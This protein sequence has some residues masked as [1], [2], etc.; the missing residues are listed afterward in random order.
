MQPCV[1]LEVVAFVSLNV[2]GG[3]LFLLLTRVSVR[4]SHCDSSSRCIVKPVMIKRY[5]ILTYL[6]PCFANCIVNTI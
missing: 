6:R 4:P 3:V 5:A 1:C 2:Y